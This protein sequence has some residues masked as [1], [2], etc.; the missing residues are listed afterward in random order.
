MV[1][2]CASSFEKARQVVR[3]HPLMSNPGVLVGKQTYLAPSPEDRLSLCHCTS[4]NW[5][6][7]LVASHFRSIFMPTH[8]HSGLLYRVGEFALVRFDSSI[9]Q[10]VIRITDI[11]VARLQGVCFN[12]I[13]RYIHT[14]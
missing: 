10:T 2:V 1:Q 11:F 8:G 13:E 14:S 6:E 9:G 3:A 4:Q 5:P 7:E 12:C